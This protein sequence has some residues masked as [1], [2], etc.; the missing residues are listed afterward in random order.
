M[1][2]LCVV[3]A[4]S[5]TPLTHKPVGWRAWAYMEDNTPSFC[6]PNAGPGSTVA[7][8]PAAH[9]VYLAIAS[10]TH[11]LVASVEQRAVLQL[12]SNPA[13]QQ[14][15]CVA[16]CRVSGH[17][18]AG[19]GNCVTIYVL[20]EEGSSSLSDETASA[21]QKRRWRRHAELYHGEPARCLAWVAPRP[22]KPRCLWVAGKTLALWS[23]SPALAS[24]VSLASGGDE[25]G[26]AKW[27]LTWSRE[28]ACPLRHM[29]VSTDGALLAT[30]GPE[31]RLV[32][33]WHATRRGTE[34]DFD[35][36]YL[37]HPCAVASLEWRPPERRAADGAADDD[38]DIYG[39]GAL[40]P[41]GRGVASGSHR[42]VAGEGRGGGGAEFL[43]TSCKDGIPRL[44]RMAQQPEPE[45]WRMFLCATLTM[46]SGGAAEDA[47]SLHTHM[48][49]PALMPTVQLVQW[50]LPT[51]RPSFPPPLPRATSSGGAAFSE[52]GNGSKLSPSARPPPSPLLSPGMGVPTLRPSLRERH[53]YLV[54]LLSDGTLI[55]WL[56]LGL[57]A[58]PRCSPKVIVWATL[59]QVLPPTRHVQSAA[60]FCN[61][62]APSPP[63]PFV[64]LASAL[65]MSMPQCAGDQLPTAISMVQH[66]TDGESSLRLCSVNVERAAMAA[67]RVRLQLLGGHGGEPIGT[68]LPHPGGTLA[69]SLD[70]GG[71]LHVWQSSTFSWVADSVAQPRAQSQATVASPAAASAASPTASPAAL[72]REA[73][74]AAETSGS[75]PKALL[76]LPGQFDAV[77]WLP[78]P[79]VSARLF[80]LGAAGASLFARDAA[81]A[82][83]SRL[84]DVPLP[85]AAEPSHEPPFPSPSDLSEGRT[86]GGE[87]LPSW[88]CVHAFEPPSPLT[89]R[90]AGES[91]DV[92]SSTG[93]EQEEE[94]VSGV[95]VRARASRALVWQ[96][97]SVS[98]T[99]TAL[100]EIAISRGGPS[101]HVTCATPL[102]RRAPHGGTAGGGLARASGKPSAGGIG[103]RL[104]RTSGVEEIGRLLCGYRD[105]AVCL[106]VLGAAAA[107]NGGGRSPGRGGGGGGGGGLSARLHLHAS[108]SPS[109]VWPPS[110][111]DW[112]VCS[113]HASSGVQCRAAVVYRDASAAAAVAAAAASAAASELSRRG[114][115]AARRRESIGYR[116][117]VIEFES[118]APDPVCEFRCVLP[119]AAAPLAAAAAGGIASSSTATGAA[120]TAAPPPRPPLSPPPPPSPPCAL[121][122]LVGGSNVLAVGCEGEVHLYVQRPPQLSTSTTE[123]QPAQWN[124]V[125]CLPLPDQ[126]SCTAAGWAHSG[127]L[128]IGAGAVM[129]V[130]RGMLG[131]LELETLPSALPQWHPASL[132]QQLLAEPRRAQRVLEHLCGQ[133]QL[134]DAEP[135]ELPKLLHA[136]DEKP[137]ASSTPSS[138]S[139][140]SG[141]GVGSSSSADLD[142]LFAPKP[143]TA[144]DMDDLFAPAAPRDLGSM[145]ASLQDDAATD[146]G[147]QTVPGAPAQSFAG[148]L[149]EKLQAE[150]S[151]G[152]GVGGGGAGGYDGSRALLPGLDATAEAALVHLLRAQQVV[153]GAG[154][155]VDACGARFLLYALG[156][157]G[158]GGRPTAVNGSSASAAAPA[159]GSGG[160]PS[161]PASTPRPVPGAAV[162]WAVLSDCHTTLLEVCLAERGGERDWASLRALGVGYWL[163]NGDALRSALEA[164]AKVHFTRSKDPVDCA[165]LYIALGKKKVLQALCK[166][167]QEQKLF[168]FLSHDFLEDRWR[169]AA[170]K[171]AYSLMS[172]QQYQ[173]GGRREA[174]MRRMNRAPSLPLLRGPKP[175]AS[176]MLHTLSAPLS[177]PPPRAPP[178]FSSP[179]S[180]PLVS[181]AARRRLLPPR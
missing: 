171:N 73:P 109:V 110:T 13:K 65:S 94:V 22:F 137:A 54:A 7:V 64:H 146:A 41:L 77:T 120:S 128:V 138:P 45:P 80:A 172:K 113:L 119:S 122:A 168:T 147:L 58:H 117:A 118:S 53:D 28:Q 107:G 155:A 145:L 30:A 82:T 23:A 79:A 181:L 154:V 68:V 152:H 106:W 149:L 97:N 148:K 127:A 125:R 85:S 55:V 180:I 140:G 99:V 21:P 173:V 141:G 50:L 95:A 2:V 57:S 17:L 163:P 100:G 116:L 11:V 158:L 167:V 134:R 151:G 38:D 20:E 176:L 103:G 108:M 177:P 4:P 72:L 164:A 33:V 142:D 76:R 8:L 81:S 174:V 133:P 161:A 98:S 84:C 87:R 71:E 153:D 70:S 130:W 34:E 101:N 46:D 62:A 29:A 136:E 10:G 19:A 3:S 49:S 157:G 129:L 159:D 43:L 83:W 48:A 40:A 14:V 144:M 75:A 26:T 111:G 143:Q 15:T 93:L 67:E 47:T 60:S 39:D 36:C 78:A 121:A 86:E 115:T 42:I 63:P 112:E 18:A 51:S 12:L 31:D 5:N 88:L 169:S 89:A 66:T 170:L 114:P 165:L 178:R 126:L 25:E 91:D 135:L 90:A 175:R 96:M 9:Q 104:D 35:F 102:P 59:P 160:S 132:L 179:L 32:K 124:L 162:A 92:S 52:F 27:E 37:R 24:A 105:G 69:A 123:H 150:S 74:P 131:A 139:K 6:R 156:L 44:W 166:A 1:L 61:F 16:F 56:V